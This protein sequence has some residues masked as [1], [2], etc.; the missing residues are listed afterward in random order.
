MPW[1]RRQTL[2]DALTPILLL[3]SFR[4]VGLAFLVP[5]VTA[6]AL[7]PRFAHP[8]AWGDLGT[9]IIALIALAAVRGRRSS[10]MALTWLFNVF[11]TLDLVNA[12]VQGLR[13]TEDGHLG[14]TWFIPAVIVPLLLVSHALVLG[15]QLRDQP[16]A[17]R[18]TH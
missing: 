17:A 18:L 1:L 12:L 10:A 9:A 11:G 15:L 4:Y 2:A 8:A 14:A 3:H 7:D 13:F 6:E 16:V 5:G